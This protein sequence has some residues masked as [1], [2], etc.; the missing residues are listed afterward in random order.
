MTHFLGAFTKLRKATLSFI[1]S[2]CLSFRPS[3]FMEQ[4][5]SH[6]TNFN[7]IWYCNIFQ[8]SLEKNSNFIEMW[9]E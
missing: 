6:W 2:V 8:K 3:V 4:L 1:M 5:S 9:Q 7:E